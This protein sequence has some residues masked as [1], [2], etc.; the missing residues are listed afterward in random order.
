M[1]RVVVRTDDGGMAANIGGAVH[2]EIKT[3]D[4]EASALEVFLR[5]KMGTY[6]QRQVV[7]VELIEKEIA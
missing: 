3:F 6:G 7:G 5:E 4:V 2:S 1:L